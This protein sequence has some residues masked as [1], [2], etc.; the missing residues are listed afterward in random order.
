MP[1]RTVTAS[2]SAGAPSRVAFA[3]YQGLGND[4]ILVS[5]YRE[6]L[7]GQAACGIVR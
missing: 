1:A 5:G 4:F 7:G 3:K 2:A 6:G